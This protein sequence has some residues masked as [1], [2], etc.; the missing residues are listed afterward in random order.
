MDSWC[1]RGK[2]KKDEKSNSKVNAFSFSYQQQKGL[3]KN[4]GKTP[5]SSILIGFS[6]INHP[7]WG[8]PIFGNTQKLQ[9]WVFRMS[10][11]FESCQLS[12]QGFVFRGFRQDAGDFIMDLF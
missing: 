3:S 6:I 9:M 12:M 10:R 5:K 2:G 11:N 7:F 4:N 8:T 1:H